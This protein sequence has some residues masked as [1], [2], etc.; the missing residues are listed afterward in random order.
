M[1]E[2]PRNDVVGTNGGAHPMVA[3]I[4]RLKRKRHAFYAETSVSTNI[5]GVYK[6]EGKTRLAA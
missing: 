6:D 2:V 4:V 3:S 5:Y 1:E